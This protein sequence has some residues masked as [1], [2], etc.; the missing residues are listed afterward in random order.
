MYFVLAILSLLY[1]VV[2]CIYSG[3]TTSFAWIWPVLT[4]LFLAMG[5]FDRK[6]EKNGEEM[7]KRLPL[8]LYTTFS[9]GALCIFFLLIFL[10]NDAKKPEVS[11]CDYVIVMGGRVYEDGI[12]TTLK[13]RLDKAIEY[14]KESPD[15]VFVLS[16]GNEANDILPEALA[17]Y[18]YMVLS[19][20]G[21]D[22]LLIE[23]D[24]ESSA[25][26]IRNSLS[27][28]EKDRM[29]RM[30]PP[31]LRIGVLS[32]DYH[33]LRTRLIAEKQTE[34]SV[35]GIPAPSDGILFIHMCVRECC[36]ILKDR[37][38]GNL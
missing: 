13:K 22:R 3:I 31:P 35:S 17:M 8:F 30:V 19:G 36:A 26:N 10:V 27:V 7:P 5:F 33:M 9:I 37:L 38:I 4:L 23:P 25:E 20:I 34:E 28:I 21:E 11:G 24:S 6:Q 2:I 14:S 1:F 18:N 15:T 16:G 29:K 12:S 32:S